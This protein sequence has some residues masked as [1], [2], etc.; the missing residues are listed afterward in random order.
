[1]ARKLAKYEV[2]WQDGTASYP[3]VRRFA[4]KSEAK[5]FLDRKEKSFDRIG[6]G[7]YGGEVRRIERVRRARPR[8]RYRR[9]PAG[10][11]LR[12]LIVPA[13]VIL[14]LYFMFRK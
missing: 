12:K 10:I 1:M 9:N 13:A 7:F 2:E 6:W 8:S 14:G 3:H 11:K 4:S 5:K